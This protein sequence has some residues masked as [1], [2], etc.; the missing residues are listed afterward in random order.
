MEAW[1][2]NDARP[3]MQFYA[4]RTGNMRNLAAMRARK[5]RL[6]VS[7][8]WEWRTEGFQYALDNG[9]WADYQ[10]GQAFDEDG[11]ERLLDQLGAGADWVIL[12]DIVAGGLESLRLSVRWLNRCL[13]V[14][15][16]ALLAV[17]DGMKAADVHGLV[18]PNV[19]VFLGGSTEWKLATMREWGEFCLQRNIYYH[20]GRVNTRR[21]MGLAVRSGANSVD[22]SSGSRYAITIPGLDHWSRQTE[23]R[24]DP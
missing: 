9:A 11:F 3:V 5:W 10:S 7:R 23:L 12:P 17:Q 6:L 15:P 14:V 18:G 1:A 22:G 16:L 19:G 21:R 13:S 20:V 2:V 24:V 4:S 8:A